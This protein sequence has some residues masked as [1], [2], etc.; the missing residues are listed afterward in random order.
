MTKSPERPTA[1]ELPQYVLDPLDR[2]SPERL[3]TIAAY[4]ETLAGWKRAQ[5]KADA[6]ATRD[7]EEVALVVGDE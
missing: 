1:P 5:C 3:E 6:T 2:Q 7:A 4:A